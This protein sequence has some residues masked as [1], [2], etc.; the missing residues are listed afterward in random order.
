MGTYQSWKKL[1]RNFIPAQLEARGIKVVYSVTGDFFG[2]DRFSREKLAEE[3]AEV[4]KAQTREELLDEL[5]DVA[6]AFDLVLKV[7]TFTQE[8]LVHARAMKNAKKGSFDKF[9]YLDSTEEPG[10]ANGQP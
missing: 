8:E 4:L 1:V 5:A 3:S 9:Y 6:E 7:N 2:R 10:N